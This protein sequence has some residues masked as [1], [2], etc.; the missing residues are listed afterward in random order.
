MRR[1]PAA[2]DLAR[3]ALAGVRLVMGST[4]LLAPSVMARRLGAN[5][6][7]HAPAG[8]ILRLFGIRTLII[9]AELLMASGP[10][11]EHAVRVAPII[12]ASD[13]VAALL[14]GRQGQLPRGAAN[15]AAVIS[16]LNTLLALVA[17][18]SLSRSSSR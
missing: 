9:G 10:R 2:G 11:R 3:Y 17:R 8:Y 12:H 18:A 16:G 6:D 5:P 14:A 15:T 7:Q 1:Q 4:A 13:T